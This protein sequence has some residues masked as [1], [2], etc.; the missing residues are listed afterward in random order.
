L[1]LAAAK[2]PSGKSVVTAA[3]S[4]DCDDPEMGLDDCCVDTFSS[5]YD[6]TFVDESGYDFDAHGA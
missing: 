2:E 5:D 4:A 3:S 1:Y 6:G